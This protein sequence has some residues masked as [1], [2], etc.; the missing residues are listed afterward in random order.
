MTQAPS[1]QLFVIDARRDRESAAHRLAS[2]GSAQPLAESESLLL[3][4]IPAENGD[5]ETRWAR[6]QALLGELG[7]AQPALVDETG[8]AHLP[9]GEISVRFHETQPEA[10]LRE[11]A[12]EHG[13]RLRDRNEFVPQQAV[14][15]PADLASSYIPRLLQELAQTKDTK[16]VWANTLTRFHRA[17]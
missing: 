1:N 13:L 2:L 6:I 11:F 5:P 10:R 15:R 14:F 9:T 12:A 4:S 8:A 3:L 7:T 17:Y 16:A